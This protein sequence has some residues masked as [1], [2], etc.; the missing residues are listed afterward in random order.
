VDDD[1]STWLLHRS[2]Q[3]GGVED[4]A[5]SALFEP[6]DPSA[7]YQLKPTLIATAKLL[8]ERANEIAPTFVQDQGSIIIELLAPTDWVRIPDR[9]RV[10][11]QEHG[12]V[13]RDL[14]PDSA[15]STCSN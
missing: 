13:A 3:L 10:R 9:L 5:A 12:Q 7:W 11:F 14:R 6:G 15:R 1:P 2:G 4:V 8:E